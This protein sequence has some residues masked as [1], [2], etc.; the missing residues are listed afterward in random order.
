MDE[1]F[2]RERPRVLNFC[3]LAKGGAACASINVHKALL[4]RGYDSVFV[5]RDIE[6]DRLPRY[7]PN[8]ILLS[9]N[10]A[11]DYNHLEAPRRPG[12]TT[13]TL[14]NTV[15]SNL[16]LALLVE[17]A[18][19]VNLT[20]AAKF[21]S[22][23][24]ISMLT[25]MGIPITIT[26]RDMQ[27]ITGGC[28]FF[29]GCKAWQDDCAN[30][31]QL[32]LSQNTMYSKLTLD[33]KKASWNLSAVTFIALSD[34]S[35]EILSRS[36]LGQKANRIKQANYVDTT[37]FFPDPT[38]LELQLPPS[39]S[40]TVRIGYLP[41]FDS[42]IK[43]HDEFCAALRTLHSMAPEAKI[44]VLMCGSIPLEREEIPFEIAP[45]G[46]IEDCGTLR[47]FYNTCD[48]VAVPSLEETFSNT[49]LEALACGTPVVGFKTGILAEL[50]REGDGG[51]VVEVGDTDALAKAILDLSSALPSREALAFRIASRFG[52][53][54]R[55]DAYD[56]TFRDLI[57]R[58]PEVTEPTGDA[59]LASLEVEQERIRTTF[60]IRRLRRER[61][62]RRKFERAYEEL[63]RK[64]SRKSTVL[65]RLLRRT[66]KKAY[67]SARQAA[68]K[69]LTARRSK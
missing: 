59:E 13:F 19:L 49:T 2:L 6:T 5:T 63:V 41:S 65:C 18:D 16:K 12:F 22:V 7:L 61:H 36:S 64:S 48:I 69:I 51:R 32:P 1:W 25:H 17:G 67:R 56:A 52:E 26:L 14:D 39:S 23:R 57:S 30:C 43:G 28:H 15:I 68:L 35:M 46:V 60:A 31:P 33:A 40:D 53:D 9:A 54:V 3:A 10:S 20:W 34:H 37:V 24:N 45:L 42:R 55:M 8:T 21:L 11:I 58:R 38:P 4:K 50:L 62:E 27:P 29:H 66:A 47:R 44:Q